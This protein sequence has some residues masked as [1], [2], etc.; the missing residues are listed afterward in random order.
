MLVEYK[1][2]NTQTCERCS[3][4]LVGIW[5]QGQTVKIGSAIYKIIG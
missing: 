3:I 5:K 1:V 2:L 4:L